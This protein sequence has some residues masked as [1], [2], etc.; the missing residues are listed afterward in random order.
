MHRERHRVAGVLLLPI[1]VNLLNNLR[2]V[3]LDRRQMLKACQITE[4]VLALHPDSAQDWRQKAA[5]LIEM[6]H[7]AIAAEALEK[8]LEL[9]PEA[10]DAAELKQTA[11]N[12]RKTLAQ[13]N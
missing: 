10:E 2:N 1:A 3:S 6:R 9:A 5:F 13:M 8:Y 12:L 11:R 7:Y 4:L